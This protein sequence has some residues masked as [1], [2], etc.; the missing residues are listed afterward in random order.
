MERGTNTEMPF[1]NGYAKCG[2]CGEYAV[3][4]GQ[5]RREG[6]SIERYALCYSQAC[7]YSVT[8]SHLKSP[9]QWQGIVS[10]ARN[11]MYGGQ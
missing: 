2:R 9:E 5:L 11:L 6:G 3:M 8:T 4:E 1:K 7:L 10:E